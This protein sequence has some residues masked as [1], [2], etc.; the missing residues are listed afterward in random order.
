MANEE[1]GL[2]E[3][4][5]TEALALLQ[6]LLRLDTT[7]PP[8]NERPAAE[9]CAES[10]RAAGLAPE[11]LEGQPGRTNLVCRLQ[12]SGE[13]PPLLLTAHLDVV[14]V[15]DGWTH[16]PFA[17]EEHGGF[18]WGRGAIDL[19]HHAAMSVTVLRALAREGRRLRR[20]VVLALVADEETGCRWGSQWLVDHHADKVRAESALG[21]LGGFT[22]SLEGRRFYPIQVAEKGGFSLRMRA[23]GPAGHGSMPREDSAV[24][25]LAEAVARLGRTPLPFH[26]TDTT[27]AFL[28]TVARALGFPKGLLLSGLL[29]PTLAPR[30]LRALKDRSLARAL[31]AMLANTV[32][33]T[34]LRAGDSLNV[35]PSEAEAR[36]D[37]RVLPGE[38]GRLFLEELRAVVGP[39]VELEVTHEEPGL[40]ARSD[41][42]LFATL[43][44]AVR[45][46]DPEGIAV[47]YLVPGSTDARAFT[48][49]GT[50]WY[51]F[52]PVRLPP[53]LPFAELFHG[54]DERIPVDGF[55]WGLRVLH[56]AVRRFCE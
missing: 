13:R 26:L 39:D 29:H 23:R 24:V 56:D 16:P 48:R 6:A 33:P 45:R 28:R 31:H 18:L 14:P 27:R 46:A 47:P 50:T 12:G 9:L 40:E 38:A 20:D 10:L 15:G 17:G 34:V 21:E 8:G 49:N 54:P 7:N 37:G 25:R 44:D 53:G 30:L 19:K 1:A 51:G 32:S 36:L 41:T 5:E 35:I 22:L 4:F 43:A 52:T 11:L 2:P 3:E 55:R 42:P